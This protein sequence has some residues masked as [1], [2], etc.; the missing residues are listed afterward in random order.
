MA[1][2]WDLLHGLAPFVLLPVVDFVQVG[3][4]AHM[5]AVSPN[6]AFLELMQQQQAVSRQSLLSCH[7][8]HIVL[9]VLVFVVS[10]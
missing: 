7:A 8:D 10:D 4:A 2:H 5:F 1:V 3:A 9:C 6:D